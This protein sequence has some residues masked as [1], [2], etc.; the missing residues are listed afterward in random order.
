MIAEQATY[1][2]LSFGVPCTGELLVG[3]RST[4]EQYKK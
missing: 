2:A 4:I 3:Y 1:H